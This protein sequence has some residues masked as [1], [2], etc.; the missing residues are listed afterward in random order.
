MPPGCRQRRAASLGRRREHR[1]VAEM[2]I[3]VNDAVVRE[4]IPPRAEHGARDAVAVLQGRRLVVEQPPAL[5]PGHGQQSLASTARAATVGHADARIIFKDQARKA[6]CGAPPARNRAPRAGAPRSPCRISA[7]SIAGFM[8]ACKANTTLSW[9]RSASTADC[10][11][12]YCSLAASRRR[13]APPPVHLSER[14]GGRRRHLE[15]RKALVPLRTKL[16]QHA[17]PHESR[18]HGRRLRLQLR[19]A[20]ARIRQEVPREWW[21]AAAPPS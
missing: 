10:M 12:G 5:E 1:V 2:R 17:S 18:A 16:R 3:A 15:A 9:V 4:R 21:P 20:P 6:R 7:V 11:S 13:R 8:R 19:P 14:S